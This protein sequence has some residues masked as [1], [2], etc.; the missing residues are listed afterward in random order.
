MRRSRVMK[1][2]LVVVLGVVVVAGCS[3]DRGRCGEGPSAETAAAV[4]AM[5]EL[6]GHG[7]F[8]AGQVEAEVLLGHGGFAPRTVA[9]REGSGGGERGGRGGFGGGFGGGGRRSG[10]GGRGGGGG[11][12]R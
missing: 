2:S 7:T 10:Y 4:A 5:P 12:D 3:M 1:P 8:L 11:G 6:E 9:N